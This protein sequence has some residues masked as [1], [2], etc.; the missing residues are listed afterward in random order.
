[1]TL[2][3]GIFMALACAFA[4]NLGFLYKFRGARDAESRVL[5][6]VPG[7]LDDLRLV[8]DYEDR[9]HRRDA[10]CWTIAFVACSGAVALPADL[11]P[12]EEL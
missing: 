3:L 8:V 7:E 2:Q 4:T 9:F 6:V 10:M 12:Y 1:M 5:Q 11:S